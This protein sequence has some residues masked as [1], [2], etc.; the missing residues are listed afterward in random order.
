MSRRVLVI[1]AS[2]QAV[3]TEKM[4]KVISTEDTELWVEILGTTF[5]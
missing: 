5:L 2:W 1:L 4:M 3:C